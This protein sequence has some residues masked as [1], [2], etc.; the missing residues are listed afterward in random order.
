MRAWRDCANGPLHPNRV[1]VEDPAKMASH[2]KEVAR[3]LGADLVGIS[4]LNQA[5]VYSH[6]GLR[7]DFAKGLAGIEIKLPHKHAI[8]IGVEMDFRRMRY[9]PGWIDNAEVGLGYLNAARI[10]VAVAA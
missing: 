7:I 5:Y 9:S 6:H 4:E 10:A 8:S 3:F 2:V 1:E